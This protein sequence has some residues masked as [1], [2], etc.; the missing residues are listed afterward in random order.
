MSIHLCDAIT[1]GLPKERE[2]LRKLTVRPISDSER[3]RFDQTLEAEHYLHNAT[4]VGAAL[5]YVAEY[6]GQWLALLI[7][8][9]PALHL[10]PRERWLHWDARRL[11]QR[12]H[13]LAQNTRFLIRGAAHPWPNLASRV[14]ALVTARLAEDWQ[15][16]FGHPVLAVET[17]VDPQRFKA[18]CY[19]AAGW[20][21]LGQTRGFERSWKDYYTDTEHPKEL[22]VRALSPRALTQLRAPCLRE[23]LGTAAEPP[24]PCPVVTAQLT[25]LW[26][27]FRREVTDPRHRRG[28]RHQM[29]CILTLAALGIAAG[30]KGPAHLAE[31]AESLNHGQRRRLRCWPNRDHPGQYCVPSQ[32]TFE[33]AL[34]E[35]D[36]EQ[37]L[38]SLATWMREQDPTRPELIHFD[39]KVCKNT[40]PAPPGRPGQ[41]NP[42]A[43][44][45]IPL[46][47]QKPKA[48][49]ALTLVNF[50]TTDQ[51]LVDQIQVPC[52]TNEEA[53]TAA[54]LPTMDLTGMC[55]TADAAHTVKANAR[56][57]TLYNG[58]EYI[59]CLKGNQPLARAK[60]EQLLS[61]ALPPSTG[62]G[63]ER[64]RSH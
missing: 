12:R 50:M 11:A 22:W 57:L 27:H 44:A 2:L 26:D 20:E 63:G 46:G 54:H 40:D 5:R 61:G 18:T 23:G 10:K 3:G 24:P 9:S 58:A 15:Q 29:P 32:S 25:S 56:Q 60:A 8:A 59:L 19:K 39:G 30:C 34:A 49:G 1:G 6:A 28:L 42:A 52:D 43:V 48:S 38:R 62:H 35:V 51:R 31:F 16:A 36:S 47:E 45:E 37:L 21:L 64:P 7:F 13:L 53:A 14:L 55:V 4:T 33:R 17:F 41:A